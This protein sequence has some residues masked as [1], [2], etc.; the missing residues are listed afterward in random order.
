MHATLYFALKRGRAMLTHWRTLFASTSNFAELDEKN[1]P[2]QVGSIAHVASFNHYF[3]RLALPLLPNTDALFLPS[4][5]TL[6]FQAN[7]GFDLFCDTFVKTLTLYFFPRSSPCL[8][9][10]TPVLTSSVT[11]LSRR[12][13]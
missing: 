2:H 3:N 11:R 12:A 5:F 10:R 13:I 9:R 6:P 4:F 8:L 1:E 7:A